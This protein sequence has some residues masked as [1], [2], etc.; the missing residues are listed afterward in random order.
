[1]VHSLRAGTD[2]GFHFEGVAPGD[3]KLLAWD[4]I[5]QDDLENPDFLEQFDSQATRVTVTGSGRAVARASSAPCYCQRA[6]Q[7]FGLQSRPAPN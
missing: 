4:D 2:G 5:A 3:Y 6:L 7:R 1:V